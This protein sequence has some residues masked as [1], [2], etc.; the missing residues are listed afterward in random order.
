MKAEK[1]IVQCPV[2][3]EQVEDEECTFAMVKEVEDEKIRVYCCSTQAK[4]V[5]NK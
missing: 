1:E 3:K 4:K 5:K 2:C